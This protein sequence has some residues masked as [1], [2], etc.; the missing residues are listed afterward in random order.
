MKNDK[1]GIG[2]A[3]TATL[4]I[5]GILV[6]L[7]AVG[8]I[9]IATDVI[10]LS[11]VPVVSAIDYDGEFEDSAVP[12]EVGGTALTISQVY[13]DNSSES[14]S[15]MYNSSTNV[16]VTAGL[17]YQYAFNLEIGDVTNLDL[18]GTLTVATTEM[19]ISKFYIIPDEKGIIMSDS[20]AVFVGTVDKDGDAFELKA[21][22]VFAGEYI[23]VVES[24]SIAPSTITSE[25]LFTIEAELDSTDNDAVDEGNIAVWNYNG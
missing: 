22:E 4:W 15:V 17:P 13:V 20:S 21:S 18:D 9:L 6:V 1:R 3:L 23:V 19:I 12:E 5:L 25:E 8:G 2:T 7:G 14:F 16:S 10:T 11:T 24:K